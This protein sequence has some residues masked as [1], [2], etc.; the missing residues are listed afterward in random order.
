MK[1]VFFIIRLLVAAALVIALYFMCDPKAVLANLK[2]TD[3]R[4][5]AAAL[6]VFLISY[7]ITAWRWQVVL[8][9]AEK[10]IPFWKLLRYSFTA[11]FCNNFLPTGFG[12][13]ITRVINMLP[14]GISA[15]EGTG[16]LFLERLIGFLVIGLLIIITLP[17]VSKDVFLAWSQGDKTARGALVFIAAAL[18]V[19]LL[20]MLF[21]IILI[22]SKKAVLKFSALFS[23]IPYKAVSK[24]FVE[25]LEKLKKI[26]FP[27][28]KYFALVKLLK[29]AIKEFGKTN[30]LKAAEFSKRLKNIIDRYNSRN[31]LS[32]VEEIIEETVDNL[33]EELEKVFKDL[34]KEKSSF[35]EMGISYIEKAFYDILVAVADEHNFRKA[36]NEETYIELARKIRELVNGKAK[37][38]DWT[39]R[40]DIRD[41]LYSDLAVLLKKNGYPPTVIDEAY[42]EVLK[43]VENF[44]KYEE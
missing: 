16:L 4:L 25:F 40:Q 5:I 39:N 10:H 9:G 37:Y 42:D 21:I 36:L 7:V 27:N 17:F 15:A 32:E 26:K 38:A 22:A 33:S 19:L 30:M 20:A 31:E 41:E 12:G 28:T 18:F 6:A 3:P 1:K 43:Q 29:R 44:K 8:Q 11:S 2:N 35:E 13:D 14:H 23:K 34:K 24:F